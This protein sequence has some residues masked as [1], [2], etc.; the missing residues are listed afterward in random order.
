[1]KNSAKT[2]SRR[3]FIA[4]ALVGGV[5]AI[6]AS[7]LGAG[8]NAASVP[9]D[10]DLQLVRN[11]AFSRQRSS[12]GTVLSTKNKTAQRM[13]FQLDADAEM[14]WE[15]VPSVENYQ[16]GQRLTLGQALDLAIAQHPQRKAEL[17]RTEALAFLQEAL[18]AG[19]LATSASRL[20][21]VRKSYRSASRDESK[22][23]Q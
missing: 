13:V 2:I 12:V 5:A 15:K 8:E 17:V 14:L 11:P 3:R 1:M 23:K 22:T 4:T 19:I 16:Q 20:V 21:I 18:R 9:S 6:A 10:T 7:Q